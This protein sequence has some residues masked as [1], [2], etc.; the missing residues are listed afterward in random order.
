MVEISLEIHEGRLHGCVV[1]AAE[2]TILNYLEQYCDEAEM[3]AEVLGQLGELVALLYTLQI[4][5][6]WRGQG[7]GTELVTEFMAQA[8]NKGATSYLLISDAN[9]AMALGFD[10][11]S[12]YRGFGFESCMETTAGPLMVISDRVRHEIMSHYL[13]PG[14]D[15]LSAA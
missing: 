11:T 9:E 14:S 13:Q 2:P 7:I 3:V 6:E 4:P 1:D 8:A 5:E 10:L 12:W 15:T